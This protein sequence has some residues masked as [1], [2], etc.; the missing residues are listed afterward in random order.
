[1]V[2]FGAG[3]VAAFQVGKMPASLPILRVDLQ[4]SLVTAGWMVGMFNFIGGFIGMAAGALGDKLGHRRM[5]LLGLACMALASLGGAAATGEVGIVISRFFEGLGAIIVFVAGPLLIVSAT[6]ARD[7]RFAFGIWSGYMPAGAAIMIALTP[8]LLGPL[9]WRGVWLV[10][11]ALLGL[12]AIILLVATRGISFG[13]GG[14][15]LTLWKDIGRVIRAPAPLLLGCIFFGYTGSFLAIT[16][17][18]PT[19]LIEIRNVAAYEAALITAAVV[20]CNIGGNVLGGWWLTKGAKRWALI[21]LASLCMGGTSIVIYAGGTPDWLRYAMCVLFSFGG[22]L[23]PASVIGG[24]QAMAPSP[25]LI[26]TSNGLVIQLGN[27]GQL[28]SPP[29][30]AAMATHIGWQ[31]APVLIA[32]AMGTCI[33]LAIFLRRHELRLLANAAKP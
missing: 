10:N 15:T 2:A 18:L 22:G 29:A 6:A 11:G 20:A 30:F 4:I 27:F 3:V 12:Y 21:C 7:M 33:V 32:G 31:S 24:A 28:V 26:G 17:F 1:M 14:R 13:G 8:L 19:Y 23:L 5:M 16:V 9:G 25:Q